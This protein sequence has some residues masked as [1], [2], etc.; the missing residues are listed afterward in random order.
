MSAN[1]LSEITPQ[2]I[3]DYLRLSETT[4]SDLDFITSMLE[5]AK[6]YIVQY[7]GH[8]L[9]E[10]DEFSDVAQVALVLCQDMY[11]TRALYVDKSNLNFVVESTLDSR[12]V[13]LL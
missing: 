6:G 8:T 13:N 12:R 10:L 2:D 9:A 5:V 1:K 3:I 4:Q 11:D 7:T